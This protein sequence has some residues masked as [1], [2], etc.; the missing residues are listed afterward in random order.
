MSMPE[1]IWWR[2]AVYEDEDGYPALKGFRKDTP[3][4]IIDMFMEEQKGIREA[5]DEGICL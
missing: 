2:Y 3:Q 4:E 5:L 1:P